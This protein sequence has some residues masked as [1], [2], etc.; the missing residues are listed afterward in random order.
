LQTRVV[1]IASHH[2]AS[3]PRANVITLNDSGGHGSPT[4]FRMELGS[5]F[6]D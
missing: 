2:S 3:S 1:V 5:G 4:G 6:L